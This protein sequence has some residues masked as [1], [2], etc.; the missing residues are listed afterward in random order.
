[1][2]QTVLKKGDRIK[3][4]TVGGFYNS[5]IVRDIDEESCLVEVDKPGTDPLYPNWPPVKPYTIRILFKH[6]EVIKEE[7]DDQ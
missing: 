1:M 5:G 3:Y 2:I 7:Q 6:T 4:K